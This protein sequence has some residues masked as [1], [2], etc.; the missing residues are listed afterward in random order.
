MKDPTFEEGD[1]V[2]TRHGFFV[3]GGRDDSHKPEGFQPISHP[4]QGR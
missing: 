3:L 1:I 2:A 4:F